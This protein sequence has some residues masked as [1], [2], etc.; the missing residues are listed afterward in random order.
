VEEDIETEIVE[1]KPEIKIDV[2]K[3]EKTIN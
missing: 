1:E 2:A 3:I